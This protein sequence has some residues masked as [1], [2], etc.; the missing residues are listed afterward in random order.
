VYKKNIR[1]FVGHENRFAWEVYLE[2]MLSVKRKT[3]QPIDNIYINYSY[4]ET[5]R[6]GRRP[7]QDAAMKIY[8]LYKKN[9]HRINIDGFVKSLL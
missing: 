2:F 6:G 7:F 1:I 5:S 4:K 3:I 8:G 9:I